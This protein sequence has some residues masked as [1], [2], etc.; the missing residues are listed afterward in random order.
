MAPVT[1]RFADFTGEE[2]GHIIASLWLY[3]AGLTDEEH[4][5]N[6][7]LT[8]EAAIAKQE[9]RTDTCQGADQTRGMR[10]T[11]SGAH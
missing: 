5:V 3:R 8:R 2:L 1:N 10:N 11:E 9:G 7:R 6:C 4:Q